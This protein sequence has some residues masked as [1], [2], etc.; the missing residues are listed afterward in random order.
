MIILIPGPSAKAEREIKSSIE[1]VVELR[2]RL[3]LLNSDII[4]YM[5]SELNKMVM[6]MKNVSVFSI[7]ERKMV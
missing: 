7:Y 2:K 3:E 4:Y 5:M 6:F 1:V